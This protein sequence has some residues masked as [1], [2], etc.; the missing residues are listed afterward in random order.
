M[1]PMK[2]GLIFS[3]RIQT[4]TLTLISTQ[5]QV[6][7][8]IFNSIV[9]LTPLRPYANTNIHSSSARNM[10]EALQIHEISN[11]IFS[12]VYY[13]SVGKKATTDILA[14]ALT[15][16]AF[17]ETALDILWHTQVNLVRLVKVLPSIVERSVHPLQGDRD[18]EMLRKPTDRELSR[19]FYYSRRIRRIVYSPHG[20]HKDCQDLMILHKIWNLYM[21]NT[22]L[23]FPNLKQLDFPQGKYAAQFLDIFLATP[24]ISLSV[25]SRNLNATQSSNLYGVFEAHSPGFQELDFGD[26]DEI[27]TIRISDNLSSLIC[28]MPD[29]R[30]LS[31]GSELISAEAIQ[32]LANLPDLRKLRV[33]CS[34]SDF[35]QLVG[36]GSKD[37]KYFPELRVFE[38]YEEN[39]TFKLSHFIQQIIPLRLQTIGIN[40]NELTSAGALHAFLRALEDGNNHASLRELTLHHRK[41]DRQRTTYVFSSD[42]IIDWPIIQ[43]LLSFPNLRA[44]KLDIPCAFELGDAAL[45]HMAKAWPRIYS[46][47]LGFIAGWGTPP[48]VTL[49]GILDLLALCPELEHFFIPFDTSVSPPLTIPIEAIRTNI[50]YLQVG[51]SGI[52]HVDHMLPVATFLKRLFPKLCGLGGAWLFV[53]TKNTE[54]AQR[55]WE[56]V[57]A[58][59]RSV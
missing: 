49:S 44:L 38:L 6:Q 14:V 7:P 4:L 59:T 11:I 10:H 35:L 52:K 13:D 23:I 16:C 36:L 57:L 56:E 48:Q 9:C 58:L 46:L 51:N 21:G 33:P 42:I 53:T 8:A 34:S 22:V 47:S 50:T 5:P 54:N 24:S 19:F 30:G 41:L 3:L 43:P 29:L 40:Y 26:F 37:T 25:A 1:L 12:I 27:K 28:R 45:H 18:L 31:C 20:M 39:F 2:K 15:C 55:S 17:Q 32:H